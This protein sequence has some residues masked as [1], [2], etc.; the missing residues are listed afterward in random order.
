MDAHIEVRAARTQREVE[1]GQCD[2]VQE[3]ETVS[4]AKRYAKRVLT[5]EFANLCESDPLGYS[6]VIKNEDCI[7]D[8][9]RS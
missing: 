4:E 7:A 2:I 6:Q 1:D 5:D 8:Y 9:F 3:F